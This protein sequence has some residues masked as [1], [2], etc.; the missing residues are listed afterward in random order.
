MFRSTFL[1]GGVGGGDSVKSVFLRYDSRYDFL[2]VSE[3]VPGN[4]LY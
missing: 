2:A 1:G 3:I 4:S